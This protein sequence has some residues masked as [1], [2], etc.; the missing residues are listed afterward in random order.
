MRKVLAGQEQQTQRLGGARLLKFR[1][2]LGPFQVEG[3]TART[4]EGSGERR[5]QDIIE[6]FCRLD[7]RKT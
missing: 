3:R 2:S 5:L 6:S 1:G 4:E 7:L